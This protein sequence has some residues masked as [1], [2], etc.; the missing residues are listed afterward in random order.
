MHSIFVS[1]FI[2]FL[3][4]RCIGKNNIFINFAPLEYKQQQLSVFH[5]KQINK[6]IVFL[7]ENWI[8]FFS[9]IH[10]KNHLQKP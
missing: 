2:V 1:I 3:I 4:I 8:R 6:I 9:F 7:K 10:I 5:E